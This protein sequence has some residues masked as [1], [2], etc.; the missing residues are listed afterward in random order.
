M[1]YATKVYQDILQGESLDKTHVSAWQNFQ[2]SRTF[3][4]LGFEVEVFHF[5]DP[6][7]T[8]S[9]AC[10]VIIDIMSNLGRLADGQQIDPVKILYPTFAHWTVHNMRSYQRHRAIAERRGVA[11]AP[12]RLVAPNDSVERADH[13]LCKGGEFGR[14]T[15]AYTE[16]PVQAVAQ[17]HPHAISEFLAR[18]PDQCR[19][20]FIWIG[21]SSAVHKGLDLVLE[22][23]SQLPEF[24]L[25]V[26]GNVPEERPFC[27]AYR[28]ELFEAENISVAGWVDTLSPRFRDICENAIGII[29]PSAT[30]LGC[31][32]VIAGMMN[33]LIPIVSEGADIDVSG[34]GV[35]L[36]E[37]TVRCVRNAVVS[38]AESPAVDLAAFSEAARDASLERYGQERFLKTFR[39]AICDALDLDPPAIW[40]DYDSALRV[41]RIETI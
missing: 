29:A 35:E 8:P 25:T 1:S 6:K 17:I 10:D 23:F 32:S 15:Y 24:G 16:T 31:G 18:K 4:D 39:A 30:E 13:I 36:G 19:K 40:D 41:P 26:I 27:S 38:L 7:Y 20:R 5:E 2:I 28:K 22:A 3:L 12:K 34:F 33:G 21:G 14:S 11:I 9:A 37:D